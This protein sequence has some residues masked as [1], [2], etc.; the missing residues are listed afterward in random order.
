[1]L[2]MN[3]LYNNKGRRTGYHIYQ[4]FNYTD[5]LTYEEAHEIGIE[6]TKRLYPDFQAVVATH[7]E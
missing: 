6:T 4:S 1:M 3:R 7:I 2:M 5:K